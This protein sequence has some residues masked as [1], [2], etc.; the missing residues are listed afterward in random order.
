MIA[1]ILQ[2]FQQ[3][4]KVATVQILHLAKYIRNPFEIKCALWRI[5][6]ILRRYKCAAPS[7]RVNIVHYLKTIQRTVVRESHLLQNLSI[8]LLTAFSPLLYF[9]RTNLCEISD[10]HLY[11]TGRCKYLVLVLNCWFNQ[12]AVHNENTMLISGKW[13]DWCF[14]TTILM[15]SMREKSR[16]KKKASM[17][18]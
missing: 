5:V 1:K 11:I 3:G 13:V 12:L 7:L 15:S 17:M 4:R 16:F 14:T 9:H 8:S 2:W 10:S 18:K 6:E